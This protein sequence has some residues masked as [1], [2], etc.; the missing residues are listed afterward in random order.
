MMGNDAKLIGH[1]GKCGCERVYIVSMHILTCRYHVH[2]NILHHEH[3]CTC[4]I[5]LFTFIFMY[6]HV[7]TRLCFM[8]KSEHV[9]TCLYPAQT[10]MYS[11]VQSCPG[12]QD[13]RCGAPHIKLCSELAIQQ[14]IYQIHVVLVIHMPDAR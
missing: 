4:Y 13:S 2:I 3:V 6:R 11:F 7:C 1:D 5:H 8:I 9:P 10:R 14:R 12:S